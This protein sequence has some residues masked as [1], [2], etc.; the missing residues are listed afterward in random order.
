ML[1][2]R[3]IASQRA[4]YQ[5]AAAPAPKA[6]PVPL[7]QATRELEL[8][9]DRPGPTGEDRAAAE[10]AFVEAQRLVRTQ[11]ALA[12]QK[13]E[14]A[15]RLSPNEPGYRALLA[16]VMLSMQPRDAETRRGAAE[17]LKVALELDPSHID[18]NFEMAR[19]L[20]SFGKP[21]NARGHLTRVL[22][23]APQHR[24]AR[25]LLAK[26]DGEEIPAK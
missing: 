5:N 24:D 20:A 12:R 3:Y 15:V 8:A 22:Q 10:R 18:A 17:Q 19:L 14:A 23:R 1:K 7:A 21:D 4:K 2:E 6:A 11:P 25:A 13:L 9:E 26:L 16:Q